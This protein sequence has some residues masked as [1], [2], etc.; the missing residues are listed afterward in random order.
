MA[1]PQGAP[2]GQVGEARQE[3]LDAAAWRRMH[4]VARPNLFHERQRLVALGQGLGSSGQ[5]SPPPM[6]A[7]ERGSIN[8]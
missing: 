8:G 3:G 4:S 7:S 2:L 5:P 1:S 6:L